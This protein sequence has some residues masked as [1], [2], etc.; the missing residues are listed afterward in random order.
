MLGII[1][2]IYCTDIGFYLL[3]FVDTFGTNVSF[4]LIVLFEVVYFGNPLRFAK[5]K[6]ELMEFGN[7]VPWLVEFSLVKFCHYTVVILLI[8]SLIS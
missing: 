2:I 8:V 6:K 7:Y 4:M 3:H 5:F 1:G